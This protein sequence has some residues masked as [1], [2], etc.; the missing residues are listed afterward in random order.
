MNI[1][2]EKF[3]YTHPFNLDEVEFH[4]R[5]KIPYAEKEQLA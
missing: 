5:E 2:K 4:V 3:E 1:L